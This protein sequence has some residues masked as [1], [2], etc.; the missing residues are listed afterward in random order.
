MPHVL[1]PPQANS[2]ESY[3]HVHILQSCHGAVAAPLSEVPLEGS[4][5][6]SLFSVI[7]LHLASHS[8]ASSYSRV[9]VSSVFG[10]KIY[11]FGPSV[12]GPVKENSNVSKPSKHPPSRGGNDQNVY[13][14]LLAVG[15]KSLHGII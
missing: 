15:T 13:V 6:F 5:V 3:D 12:W 4:P 8:L 14:G 2:P 10:T 7:K 11:F 9:T 1:Q